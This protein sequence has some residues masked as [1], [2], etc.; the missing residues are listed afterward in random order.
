MTTKSRQK[1][2]LPV[3]MS[4]KSCLN[5]LHTIIRL[6]LNKNVELVEKMVTNVT[7]F[8]RANDECSKSIKEC[9]MIS[10]AMKKKIS[11]LGYRTQPLWIR[12]RE[13]FYNHV[14][15]FTLAVFVDSPIIVYL[16]LQRGLR[17]VVDDLY[18]AIAMLKP[19]CV[20]VMLTFFGAGVVNEGRSQ[21]APHMGTPFTYLM[22]KYPSYYSNWYNN[23]RR[24]MNMILHFIRMYGADLLSLVAGR[25]AITYL[26]Q[27]WTHPAIDR[28]GNR[29]P[30]RFQV[31]TL[32]QELGT[33]NLNEKD[34]KKK[35][36]IDYFFVGDYINEEVIMLH[37][38]YNFDLHNRSYSS[39]FSLT[40][41]S[42][43]V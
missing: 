18:T 34:E 32:L 7:Y 42:H 10:N 13:S 9:S 43:S 36:P 37:I 19:D 25:H 8:V 20:D 11:K 28:M 1:V 41:T 2:L 22:H 6:I 16:L 3:K 17:P 21:Q 5:C 12:K 15:L 30:A 23:D 4:T 14:T 29:L 38:D 35:Y 33:V 24:E 39:K 31:Q 27:V 40:F 26:I